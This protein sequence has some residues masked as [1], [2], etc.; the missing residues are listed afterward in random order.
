MEPAV[1]SARIEPT[2]V[3]TRLETA[4]FSS[5]DS[6]S[7]NRQTALCRSK[8]VPPG[9]EF[10][11]TETGGQKSTQAAVIIGRDRELKNRRQECR[12]KRPVSDRRR[13]AQFEKTG[14]WLEAVVRNPSQT[15]IRAKY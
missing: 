6:E 4:F 3:P 11:D 10:L 8:T 1:R 5:Q 7:P 2:I 14:W 12:Q 15:G 13:F 9:T